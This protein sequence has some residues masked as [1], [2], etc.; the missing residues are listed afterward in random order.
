MHLKEEK[1]PLIEGLGQLIFQ[2]FVGN[3]A[4]DLAT[5]SAGEIYKKLKEIVSSNNI[6]DISDEN[7]E[8][9]ATTISNCIE[10]IK[11][12]IEKDNN[13]NQSYEDCYK[14]V[15]KKSLNNAE[16]SVI[17]IEVETM[18][19]DESGNNPKNSVIKIKSK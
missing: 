16:N 1:M 15:I 2:A 5:L 14:I 11:Q 13:S 7:I 9:I 10:S 12:K 17:E 18:I 3:G 4:Y 19:M 6:E 8:S